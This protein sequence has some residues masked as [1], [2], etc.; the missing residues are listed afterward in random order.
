MTRDT[1]NFN[2]DLSWDQQTQDASVVSL[3]V[4]HRDHIQ[5]VPLAVD[6]PMTLGRAAPADVLINSR[7]LS[8]VHCEFQVIEDQVQVRDLDSTNGTLL[9]GV[10]ISEGILGPTDE[11]M[12]GSVVVSL[13]PV[14]AAAKG[15]EGV[16]RH[17]EFTSSVDE[18][19]VRAR[20]F[21]RGLTVMMVQMNKRL[22]ATHFMFSRAI[23]ARVVFLVILGLF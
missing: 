20:T 12:L 7:R 9:N 22:M 23:W 1:D 2:I 21:G 14:A 13:Q 8:R 10:R 16:Q 5:V 18:E 6:R 17:T 11:V 19:L 4:V 15:L 3:M